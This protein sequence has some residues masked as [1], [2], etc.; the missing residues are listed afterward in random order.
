MSCFA[1][2]SRLLLLVA[3]AL[4]PLALAAQEG[5]GLAQ[6]PGIPQTDQQWRGE[7]L[8]IQNCVLCHIPS[9]Q[10]KY[11]GIQAQTLLIGAFRGEKPLA[12]ADARQRI[13]EGF[14]RTMPAFKY[15]LN[16]KQLDDLIAYL[17]IR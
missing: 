16:S 14:P 7:A 4:F 15:Q 13:L 2:I 5:G 3:T 1:G 6:K 11:L 17:K 9:A 12:E 10:K 8:F